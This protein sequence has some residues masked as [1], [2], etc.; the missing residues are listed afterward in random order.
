MRPGV[1]GYEIMTGTDGMDDLAL[2]KPPGFVPR[3]AARHHPAVASVRV[4]G[5]LAL[6]IARSGRGV[7]GFVADYTSD[8]TIACFRTEDGKALGHDRSR[9][10]ESQYPPP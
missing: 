4:S 7:E 1:C 3:R 8:L 10:D 2:A 9:L 5:P 6:E